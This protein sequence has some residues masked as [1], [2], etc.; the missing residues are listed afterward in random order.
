VR[1]EDRPAV[2]RG[3]VIAAVAPPAEADLR[4]ELMAEMD[5]LDAELFERT[6]FLL[7]GLPELGVLLR[8]EREVPAV[9]REVFGSHGAMFRVEDERQW[10]KAEARLRQSLESFAQTAVG[11]YRNRLFAEDAL[12]GLRLID[13]VG[14]KFDVVVTN[15][16]FGVLSLGVKD[17]LEI[18]YVRSKRDL[19]AI[20]LERGI[21]IL[22]K[23]GRLV[24]ITS[25]TC[26]FLSSFQR[27]RED[28]VLSTAPP[29]AFADLGSGVLDT[30]MVEVAAYCLEKLQAIENEDIILQRA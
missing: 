23:Q 21:E 13:L 6:L 4:R 9:V 26:F 11:S 17:Q 5:E 30:A 25:R 28:I 15:P 18:A 10:G 14:E 12:E 7:K 2:G 29:V 19:L 27:W 22:R 3:H 20:F 24:A 8:A 16:P 1:R